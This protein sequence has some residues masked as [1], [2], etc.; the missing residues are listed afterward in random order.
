[1]VNWG[2]LIE[3]PIGV[4]LLY[5]AVVMIDPL[6][7]SLFGTIGN[8]ELIFTHGVAIKAMVQLVPLILGVM[9]LWSAYRSFREPDQPSYVVAQ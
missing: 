8:T 7:D 9:L 3:A 6:Q 4:F 5:A 2:A 1:M